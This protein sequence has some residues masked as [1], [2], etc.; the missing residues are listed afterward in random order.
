[1]LAFNG[2]TYFHEDQHFRRS[3]LWVL[4]ALPVVAA[5]ASIAA[6]PRTTL[7]GIVVT[8]LVALGV[9]LLFAFARLETEVRADG[10]L[11][12]FHGLWPT[13]RI[14]LDSIDTYA[15]RH[16]SIWDSGGWG[17]HLGLAG[18]TYNV[19]GNDGVQLRLKNGSRVLVGTQ[20]P[21][22]FVSAIAKAIEAR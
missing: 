6:R 20:R 19:S 14:P 18:M 16:Y 21:A 9:A 17:V 11:V 4:I 2:V 10:I 15:A 12:R 5:V 8:L 3:W 22:E 1:M 13:R 7:T